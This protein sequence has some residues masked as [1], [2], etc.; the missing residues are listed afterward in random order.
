M[1]RLGKGGGGVALYVRDSLVTREQFRSLPPESGDH[2][3]NDGPPPDAFDPTYDYIKVPEFLVHEV[4]LNSRC[5]LLVAVIYRPPQ[6]TNLTP[7]FALISTLLPRYQ[8]VIITGDLNYNMS[9]E[10][11]GSR[12]LTDQLNQHSLHLVPS[13]PTHHVNWRDLHTHLDL[14]IVGDPSQVRDYRKSP[15]PFIDGHDFIELDLDCPRP[16][17]VRKVIT[18][19]Q[20][21]KINQPDL[22]ALLSQSL[23][24]PQKHL[25]ADL[26]GA[27]CDQMAR[28]LSSSII[29]AF[30][31][32][33]PVK[34]I[35]LS[36]RRKP[37]V[38]PQI[39]SLMRHRDRLYNAYR[40]SGA[41]ADLDIYRRARSTVSNQLDTAR[42]RYLGNKLAAATDLKS[43]W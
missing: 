28:S 34:S 7:F 26:S 42:N 31:N 37:W 30:D 25:T 12:Y 1:D 36:T 40:R 5:K 9:T 29:S 19:R 14:F 32:T 13:D 35:H 33:A 3:D 39:L 15:S 2:E 41:S 22:L 18:S 4:T 16:P 43:K 6:A 38:S 27:D 24:Q 17:I 21:T 8:H 23:T 11:Y 20:L 10:N